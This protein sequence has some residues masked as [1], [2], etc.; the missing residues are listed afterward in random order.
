MVWS[1]AL[2]I[3]LDDPMP[4]GFKPWFEHPSL[5]AQTHQIVFGHWA[6]LQGQTV[7]DNI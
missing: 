2:K 6:A 4:E 7:A 3:A 1:S 5:A